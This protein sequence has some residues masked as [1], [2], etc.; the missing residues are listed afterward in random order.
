MLKKKKK[1]KGKEKKRKCNRWN[2]IL[3]L[4]SAEKMIGKRNLLRQDAIT[5][6]YLQD[7]PFLLL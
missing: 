2:K 4:A 7:V 1:K 5:V 6:K 3:H